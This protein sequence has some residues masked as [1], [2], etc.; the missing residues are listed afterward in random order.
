MKCIWQEDAYC[1]PVF[2]FKANVQ[3]KTLAENNVALKEAK[4]QCEH[5]VM[6]NI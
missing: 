1:S 2:L 6:G 5:M 3:E 4:C